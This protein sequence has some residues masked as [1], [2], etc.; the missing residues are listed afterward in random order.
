[1]IKLGRQLGIKGNRNAIMPPSGDEAESVI[2][3]LA[4]SVAR[5]LSNKER[6]VFLSRLFGEIPD[7]ATARRARLTPDTVAALNKKFAKHFKKL[8]DAAVK[9][10]PRLSAILLDLPDTGRS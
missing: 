7:E 6:F 2:C 10:D 9:R 4:D 5:R 1:M 3:G 8:R